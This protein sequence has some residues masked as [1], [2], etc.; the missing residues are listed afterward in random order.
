LY[1]SVPVLYTT[2]T[3]PWRLSYGFQSKYVRADLD[4]AWPERGVIIERQCGEVHRTQLGK[5]PPFPE[6]S[7]F[8]EAGCEHIETETESIKGKLSKT[9]AYY[10]LY[11]CRQ[12]AAQLSP[13]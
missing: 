2:F 4:G 11:R 10:V 13:V 1:T 8:I 3:H 5:G 12:D 9:E 6:N 7:I